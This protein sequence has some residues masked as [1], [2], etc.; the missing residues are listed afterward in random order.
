MFYV[1]HPLVLTD[2]GELLVAL[3]LEGKK[4][5]VEEVAMVA[6][7]AYSCIAAEYSGLSVEAMTK[8]RS[9]ARKKGIYVRVVRNTLARRALV[10]TDFACMNDQLVGPL[11][12]AFSQEDPGSVARVMGDFAKANNKL[13]IKVVSFSGRL[14]DPA[15]LKVLANMP[16]REQALA[17]LMGLL[18]APITN[19]VR[20]LA[21]PSAKLVRTIA[22]IR[23]QKQDIAA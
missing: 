15:D 7:H 21:E 22:A 19:F 13:I 11:V 1:I 12:L 9:E 4:V 20:T 23:D 6:S 8:L 5:I 18:K 17:I 16:T 10:G 2:G 3:N 14:L